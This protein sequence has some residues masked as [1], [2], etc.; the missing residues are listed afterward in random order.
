MALMALENTIMYKVP[1]NWF[2]YIKVHPK[3]GKM[4]TAKMD[5]FML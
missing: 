5:Y 2:I 3:N 1:Q 4:I